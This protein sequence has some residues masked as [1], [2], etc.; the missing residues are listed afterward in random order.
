MFLSFSVIMEG[1]ENKIFLVIVTNGHDESIETWTWWLSSF[2]I[3]ILVKLFLNSVILIV[4]GSCTTGFC[5]F[6][7]RLP[8]L[9]VNQLFRLRVDFE[10]RDIHGSLF[11]SQT[12]SNTVISRKHVNF[13]KHHT[14]ALWHL[15]M[16]SPHTRSSFAQFFTL[17]KDNVVFIH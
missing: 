10:V 7:H 16:A 6:S 1:L 5:L 3:N 2:E 13:R 9:L 12:I 4:Y 17:Q 11:L 8:G 15:D 14:V